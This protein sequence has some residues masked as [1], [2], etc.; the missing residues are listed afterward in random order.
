MTDRELSQLAAVAPDLT[1]LALFRRLAVYPRAADWDNPRSGR[2]DRELS[3]LA[4]LAPEPTGLALFKRL[5]GFAR[6]AD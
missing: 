2:T 5:S 6:A 4:A 3:Q 1:G